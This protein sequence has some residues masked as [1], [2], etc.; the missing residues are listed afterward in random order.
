MQFHPKIRKESDGMVEYFVAVLALKLQGNKR[1]AK[2]VSRN[3]RKDF[4]LPCI[5]TMEASSKRELSSVY[6][7]DF[8]KKTN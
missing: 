2:S 7:K 1:H 6:T 5:P 3:F 8:F 4:F